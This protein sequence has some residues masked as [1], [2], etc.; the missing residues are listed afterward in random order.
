MVLPHWVTTREAVPPPHHLL[1]QPGT[2]TLSL[3]APRPI[4]LVPQHHDHSLYWSLDI[5]IG[6]FSVC[7]EVSNLTKLSSDTRPWLAHISI[8]CSSINYANMTT[9]LGY[10]DLQLWAPI[11]RTVGLVNRI[12]Y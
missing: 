2:Q 11:R 12:R 9:L 4:P 5:H 3:V 1:P 10:E 8:T 7:P 6:L